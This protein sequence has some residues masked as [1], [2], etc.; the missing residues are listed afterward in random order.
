VKKRR[1]PISRARARQCSAAI[2][3]WQ[4]C[5]TLAK[6]KTKRGCADC[7]YNSHHA[8]LD[9]DHLPGTEKLFTVSAMAR[10]SWR[11]VLEEI[12]KCEVVC[13][14]CHRI[15]TYERAQ[16]RLRHHISTEESQ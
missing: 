4:F 1:F 8:A 14:N 9:F 15:R 10:R 3:R 12:R 16:Q 5:G 2:N 6:I 7:G 11:L 13:A